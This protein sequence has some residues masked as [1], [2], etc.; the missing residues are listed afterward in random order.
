[1]QSTP[2]TPP[3][4][5]LVLASSSK[6]WSTITR[7]LGLV[8]LVAFMSQLAAI[9]AIAPL[10]N[11]PG[12]AF[13]GAICMIPFVLIF[14]FVRRDKLLD[15]HLITPDSNGRTDHMLPGN[16]VLRSPQ[17]AI[18]SRHLIR[19]SP[20]LEI[21]KP[22][23][24]WM[25]FFGGV[26][27][28]IAGF[29]PV[30]IYPDNSMAWILAILIAIPALVVG[31]ATPAFAWW[32]FSTTHLRLKTSR[33]AGEGMLIAG[34]LSTIPAIIINSAL[35][36]VLISTIGISDEQIAEL[37][38]LTISAPV[39]EELCKAAAVL[40]C[41][42]FIN[43]A[44][45]GFQVGCAVGLGFA[46]V[47]N[48]FYISSS[49]GG[50]RFVAITYGMTSVLRGIGS[51]PGH[52]LWTGISGYAIGAHRSRRL[53]GSQ[54]SENWVLFDQETGRRISATGESL[55]KPPNWL[56]INP[57]KAWNLPRDPWIA[58]LFAIIGHAIWNGS[59]WLSIF[60]GEKVAGDA[61]IIV[62]MISWT[63][64]LLIALWI[65]GR[66][67]LASVFLHNS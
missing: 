13:G 25:L 63:L 59:S 1:M 12:M 42:R 44:K 14:F 31:F 8:V 17:P 60:V 2:L 46:I 51:I 23:I 37:L 61:G 58:I 24:L 54:Q 19:D 55:V 45:R 9:I 4:R 64:V 50:G 29:I 27:I 47:E 38:I 67:V 56:I 16:R 26:I 28:S 52:A 6:S 10:F 36:P 22:S 53:V 34:M 62:A 49:F 18:A 65:V 21:P 48:L 7:M 57:E 11:E 5:N 20:P 41:S 35:F 15:V 3:P 30:L 32:S 39:G 33:H 40:A 66:N 43:S